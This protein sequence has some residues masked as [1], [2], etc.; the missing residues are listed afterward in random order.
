MLCPIAL[1]FVSYHSSKVINDIV[2]FFISMDMNGG[3]CMAIGPNLIS[4]SFM[5]TYGRTVALMESRE[6]VDLATQTWLSRLSSTTAIRREN[7]EEKKKKKKPK[8][9]EVL[10]WWATPRS[11]VSNEDES[12]RVGQQK[13]SLV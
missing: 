1:V 11:A 2:G 3:T 4:L 13:S 9:V 10:C 12:K 8:D 5:Y 7:D 6:V